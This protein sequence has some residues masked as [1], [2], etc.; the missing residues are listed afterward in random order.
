MTKLMKYELA[1]RKQ[2]FIGAAIT[3]LFMEGLTLLGIYNGGGLWRM[4]GD[5]WDGWNVLAITMTALLVIGGFVLAFLDAVTRLYSDYKQKQG[6][7][8]LMTPQS[9][10]RVIWAK[11]IFALLDILAA[12]LV[13]AGCLA[14]SCM[15]IENVYGGVT[16][17]FAYPPADIDIIINVGISGIILGLF[18]IMAQLS[19]AILA[20]TVARVMTQGKSYNWLIAL[21]MYFALAVIVNVADGALLVAFGVV[22]D[23]RL[24]DSG[25]PFIDSGLLAKYC[26]IGAVTYS[27]WFAGCTLLSGRL[28]NRGIDI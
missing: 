17:F 7:M 25:T 3:I 8:I 19:I 22:R 13:I 27:A 24:V 20:V 28:I 12:G 5:I 2:M 26:I 9:G 23:I 10:Y 1:R 4:G 14:L 21:L 18:Q 6:Y 11:T 15:A 16:K